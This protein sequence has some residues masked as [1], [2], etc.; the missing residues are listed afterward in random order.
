V[1]LAWRSFRNLRAE[2]LD[3]RDHERVQNGNAPLR[4]GRFETQVD[5]VLQAYIRDTD[6]FRDHGEQGPL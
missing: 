5:N 4:N 2:E 1:P 3:L 6:L